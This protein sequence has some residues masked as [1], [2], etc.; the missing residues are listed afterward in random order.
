MKLT[1]TIFFAF[2]FLLSFSQKG[3][4]D[5]SLNGEWKFKTD[6]NDKG[7]VLHWFSKSLND[8]EWDS[9]TVPGNWDLRNEYAHYVGKSWYR[10]DF[11]VGP[12][13]K[14]KVVRLLFQAVTWDSKVWVNGKLAGSNNIGYLPFEMNVS[15]V[16]NYSGTNTIVVL[17]D[18]T[19]RVGALWNWGGIRRPVQLIATG[20][21]YI[22]D[23]FITPT[24]DLKTHTAKVA[25]KVICKNSGTATENIRGEVMLSA[26]NGFKKTLPFAATVPPD[27][28]KEIIVE[29]NL[30]SND[31]HLWNSDDPFLY[32]SKVSIKN[33]AQAIINRFGLRKIEID[34]KNFTFKLNGES[35]RPMG[36]NL[37]PD[38]RTT[39]STLP[40]WRVKEDV[41]LMKS[42]GANMARLTHLPLHKEMFDYLDEKGILVF[43][44]IPLWG[45][46]QLVDKNN[47]IPKQ[48]LQR[49]I[50]NNYNHPCIIGWSVG[51]EIG[52][53][54]GVMEYVE[55]AIDF[56]KKA[57]TSRLAVMI[58][59]TAYRP[60]DPVQFSDLGLINRYGPAI[61]TAADKIHALHPDKVLFYSEYGYGQLREDL[62]A[63]VDAKGM[64]DSLRF[65]PYL[66]GGSLWTFNDYRSS[67]AGTKE[68]SENRPWGIV[69][70]F[71]QKKEAWYSFRKQYAPIRDVNIE[72]AGDGSS[73]ANLVIVPRK[74]LDLPAYKLKDYVLVWEGYD[75]NNKIRQS[76]LIKL[77]EITPGDPAIRQTI[78]WE[79]NVQLSN[80]KVELVSPLNYSVYDTTVY[81]KT[82]EPAKIEFTYGGRTSANDTGGTNGSIRIVFKR[83]QPHV[84]Y[85]VKYGVDD[86]SDETP[87]TLNSFI[88][89]P[90]LTFGKTYQVAVVGVNAK[91]E[92]KLSEKT[93]VKVEP[94]LAPPLIYYVEPAD[95]GF[96]VGYATANNDYVFKVQYSTKPGDYSNATTI[97]SLTKGVLFVPNLING[98][99]YYFRMS[100]IKDNNYR[101][102]WSEEHSVIPDGNQ[103][104]P[105][106]IVQ[107]VIRNGNEAIVVFEP[108][109][110][111]IGYTV[112]YRL[113]NSGEWRT[114][115]LS[116]AQL[117]HCR[118]TGLNPNDKYEF[119]MASKNSYGE[120]GFTEAF[121]Q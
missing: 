58:S 28:S 5:V 71:R 69:D 64:V 60:K 94:G 98:Q 106:P 104:P 29:T 14:N 49:L 90:K 17:A 77:P 19:F 38:D 55:D 88:D 111:A 40:L 74:V 35:I 67:F 37:V 6:L 87:P 100:R 86:L 72:F 81:F 54:P 32:E 84:Y 44:E 83:D 75:D 26:I 80:L 15:S 12:G 13:W 22:T 24:V 117:K 23:Q 114:I 101:T 61:G 11:K 65:K 70:V 103:L 4:N 66:I 57:D 31:V 20:N 46:D 27:G 33:D 89:I 52:D 30:S 118:I 115:E 108:V 8:Q 34:N 78:N 2:F 76:G 9:M 21:T 45:L 116:A 51:N 42:L 43:S 99:P 3:V 16:L 95:K 105:K 56:V 97:Q 110:K 102:G 41:D 63:D 62:D 121:S 48:W 53:S 18:N 92:G 50:N 1:F 79:K 107:G 36:F 93:K 73:S 91:G 82:P 96:Y 68:F 85:K 25:V 39:G 7:E 47:P 109:K 120:S 119:R 112:Q 113:K 10:K 59:H